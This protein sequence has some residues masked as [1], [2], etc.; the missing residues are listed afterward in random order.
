V[1]IGLLNLIGSHFDIH[2]VD[3][4]ASTLVRVFALGGLGST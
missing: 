3:I 4:K 1:L 2:T